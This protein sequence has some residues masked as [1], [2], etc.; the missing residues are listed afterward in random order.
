[1]ASSSPL[2]PRLT[3]LLAAAC[4]LVVANLYYAQALV[5]EIAP[6]I[7]L[8]P[9]A[10]GLVVTATQLGYGAGLFLLVPLA[11]LVE[12]RRLVLG[13]TGVAALASLGLWTA[14]TAD[15]FLLLSFV[16]GVSSVGAQVLVPL[17]AHLAP[18]ASRGRV[19][20]NVMG[21]LIAGIM[22]ARPAANALAAVA[23]WRAI[24]LA[25]AVV[26]AALVPVLWRALPRRT[27]ARTL[28]YGALIGSG[29]RLVAGTPVIRRRTAYQALLFTAF[30]LFWT[31]V[32]LVLA[33]RFGLGQPGIALFA[34]AG[35]GGAL[36]APVAGRLGDRGHGQRG[37][38]AALA[39]ATLSFALAGWAGAAGA[40]VALGIAAVALDAAVQFNQVLG[41]RMIY[42]VAADARGRINAVYMTAVFAGGAAGSLLASVSFHAGGWTA[43]AVTGGAIAATALAL[44]LT[45]PRRTA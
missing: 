45:E 11:D 10:S 20:G 3:A 21:G 24:F 38:A 36:A 17:A 13:L 15:V 30:S 35:A 27:P 16:I 29:V 25:A 39:V 18:D 33:G 5:G 28:V 40:L 8:R 19:L 41:Q 6:A 14:R 12:N 2:S 42:A 31:A 1:M 7:G 34:L 23:G 43:T 32:P 44:F 4:G 22:L 26:L 9:Q 37:T